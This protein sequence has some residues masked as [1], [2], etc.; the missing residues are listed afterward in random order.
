MNVSRLNVFKVTVS[1]LKLGLAVVAA[2][3]ASASHGVSLLEEVVVTA[4]K[5]EQNAQDISIAIS[6]FTGEQ[7]Q[8]LGIFSAEDL[9]DYVPGVQV[10]H[11]YSNTPSFT[12]R[13]LNANDYAFATS[14]AVAIYQDGIYKA[15]NIN[16]GVQIFDVERIEI[17][18]GPQGTLWGK[19]TTGGAVSITSVRPEQETSGYISLGYGSFNEIIAEG[20]VGGGLTEN[21]SGRISMQYVEADGPYDNVTFPTT[22]IPPGAV[23][24]PSALNG[25]PP[26][27]EIAAGTG[28]NADPGAIDTM[29]IRGQLLW[30]PS[31][32]FQALVIGHFAN[33]QSSGP[34]VVSRLED[35]DVYDDQ[36]S[37]DFA[38]IADNDF[39]GV[40]ADLRWRIGPGELVSVTGWDA[41]DRQ[42]HGTD[43]SNTVP[44]AVVVPA[45]TPFASAIYAQDFEQFSQEL[46]YEVQGDSVFWLAGMYYSDTEYDQTGDNNG[47]GTFGQYYESQYRQTDDFLAAF[48]HAEWAITE[49]LRLNTGL[50]YNDESRERELHQVYLETGF[51]DFFQSPNLSF[52]STLLVDSDGNGIGGPNPFP[53]EFDTSGLTYRVGLDWNPS[54]QML[55]Y[56]SFSKGLKSGGFESSTVTSMVNLAPIEDE[57]VLAHEIGIKWDPTDSLRFNAAA[58]YYDYTEMQQR[59]SRQDPVFGSVVLLTNLEQADITGLELEVVWAP[60]EGLEIAATASFLDTEIDSDA[61]SQ[62]TGESLNGKELANAPETAASLLARY[63]FEIGNGLSASLQASVNYT[64]DH[65]VSIENLAFNQQDFTL[66]DARVAIGSVAGKWEVSVYGQNLTDEIYVNVAGFASLDYWISRPRT[67]GVR[68]DYRF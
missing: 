19:N 61:V 42:D 53:N 10:T 12:V 17:L 45:A 30:E 57:E 1:P 58:F 31:D 16:S 47:M 39:Y 26:P 49:A 23:P 3:L 28:P 18:K 34:A 56:Y 11:Q 52:P 63:G 54:E 46:R 6:A 20:A 22:G 24:L 15:S 41:F 25:A 36:V 4:Q 67:Y 29:A 32:Q 35:P 13:G 48:V 40:T 8:S 44:G 37:V 14:P 68:L 50:R 5:R 65:F 62:G 21:L 9:A 27:A 66:V 43:L 2:M 64:G 51:A 60:I 7:L 59:V 55:L 33:H 38:P